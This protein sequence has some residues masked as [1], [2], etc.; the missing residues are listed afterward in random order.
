MRTRSVIIPF[1]LILGW[2][3]LILV[4]GWFVFAFVGDDKCK[5][6]ASNIKLGHRLGIYY[7]GTTVGN[8]G[9]IYVIEYKGAEY[10]VNTRGGIVKVEK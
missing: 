4:L 6:S 10:L 5:L 1:S 8:T 3:V 7:G 9:E 2:I